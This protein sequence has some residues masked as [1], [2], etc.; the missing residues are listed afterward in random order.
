MRTGACQLLLSAH[1]EVH[2]FEIITFQA[3]SPFNL[4]IWK[5]GHGRDPLYSFDNYARGQARLEVLA[6]LEALSPHESFTGE[7]LR[8]CLIHTGG[9][10]VCRSQMCCVNK[11][12]LDLGGL[13][14]NRLCSLSL[15][16]DSV[17]SDTGGMPRL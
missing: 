13:L 9:T 12:F 15:V 4:I 7:L 3:G 8:W 2:S 14:A 10:Y 1:P 17:A 11:P 6:T 16:R 5:L